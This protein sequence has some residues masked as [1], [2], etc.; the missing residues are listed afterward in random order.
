VEIDRVRA[1]GA[2][3]K[4]LFV[5]DGHVPPA[6]DDTGGRMLHY[7]RSLRA[8]VPRF[9]AAAVFVSLMVLMALHFDVFGAL[10]EP[11]LRVVGF[12]EPLSG[13]ID[14]RGGLGAM[15]LFLFPLVPALFLRRTLDSEARHQLEEELQGLLSRTSIPSS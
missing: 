6:L 1:T 9:L 7:R 15:L 5:T 8:S 14:P 11:A 13:S 3:T 2:D 10:L 12:A 4:T